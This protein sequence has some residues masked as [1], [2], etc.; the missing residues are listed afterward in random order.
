MTALI[1]A[2]VNNASDAAVYSAETP[3]PAADEVIRLAAVL[4]YPRCGAVE[5]LAADHAREVVERRL[6]APQSAEIETEVT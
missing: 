5:H 2:V 3:P 1:F 6:D 4:Q